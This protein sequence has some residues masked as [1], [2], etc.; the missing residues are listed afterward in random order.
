[1]TPSLGLL[2]LLLLAT[3]RRF[4]LNPYFLFWHI[5]NCYASAVCIHGF[6]IFFLLQVASFYGD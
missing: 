5:A 6:C 4:N 1:M 3:F 2:R